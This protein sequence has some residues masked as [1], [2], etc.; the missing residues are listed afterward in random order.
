MELPIEYELEI[1]NGDK[2]LCYMLNSIEHF[3][4]L[5]C[6]DE[7]ANEVHKAGNYCTEHLKICIDDT[8]DDQS[9]CYYIDDNGRKYGIF[10]VIKKFLCCEDGCTKR[11]VKKRKCLSHHKGT[12]GKTSKKIPT[13][14][15]TRKPKSVYKRK[16]QK[17]DK[18]SGVGCKKWALINGKCIKCAGGR[19]RCTTPGCK[20]VSYREGKCKICSGVK[21]AKCSVNGC[22]KFSYIDGKCQKCGGK[23]N[24]S[25]SGCK[26]SAKKDGKCD[27]CAGRISAKC[28]VTEC[29]K[30]AV[31]NGKCSKCGGLWCLVVGCEKIATKNGKCSKCAGVTHIKCNTNGCMCE[32]KRNGMCYSCGD[33]ERTKCIVDGCASR[34]IEPSKFCTHHGGIRCKHSGCARNRIARSKCCMSHSPKELA[35]QERAR[36]KLYWQNNPAARLAAN[37][38]SRIY[39][40]LTTKKKGHAVEF[41]GCAFEELKVYLEKKFDDKMSWGNYGFYGWHMDHIRPIA[42]FDLTDRKQMK[43]CFHYTN[44]QPLWAKDNLSKGDKFDSMNAI[45]DDSYWHYDDDADDWYYD[46]GEE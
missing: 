26:R 7:C 44:L 25:T 30:K 2:Y 12:P 8:A 40:S 9:N 32:A 22:T 29:K 19:P 3:D 27:K 37:I 13:K 41:L 46:E 23:V 5:C 10:G 1:I 17:G 14:V 18:C 11:V 45:D 20:H 16:Q 24:C 38:R 39:A 6:V 28:T 4:K 33:V 36:R 34:L 43:K 31:K 15:S 21:G 42:S 35:D